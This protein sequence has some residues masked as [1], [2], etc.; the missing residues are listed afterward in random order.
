MES[1]LANEGPWIVGEFTLADIAVAPYLFRLSALGE[2]R[3]WSPTK[4]SHV[5]DWYRRILERESFKK[6]VSWPHENGAGYEEVGL[7]AS[8]PTDRRSLNP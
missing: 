3:F 8:L 1:C 5:A 6:A 4:R 7:H 2:E